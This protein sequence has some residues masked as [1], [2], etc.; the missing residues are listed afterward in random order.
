MD[1]ITVYTGKIWQIMQGQHS[2]GKTFEKVVRSPG[3]R[4]IVV[5]DGKI[6]LSREKRRE[7]D[8][9]ID[10]RLPGG[11]VFDTNQEYCKFLETGADIIEASRDSITREALEEV[12]LVIDPGK[13]NYIGIDVLGATC[14]WDLIYWATNE[15]TE[16][17]DGAKHT[18]S[19]AEEIVDSVWVDFVEAERLALDPESFSE[20]R[21]ARMLL[22]YL[23]KK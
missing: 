8:N 18:E 12:G 7:L 21:S 23:G 11:K 4:L 22:V 3:S 15:S 6:L 14:E 20:S 17:Q 13:L 16:N 5:S 10:Y 9:K 1:W 19:E 2:S